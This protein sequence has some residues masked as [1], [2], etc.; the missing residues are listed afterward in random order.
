MQ[1]VIELN[2]TEIM[3]VDGGAITLTAIAAAVVA[4]A[5]VATAANE[6]IEVGEKIHDA[7]CDH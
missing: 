2:E 6:I 1:N 3:A 5:A 7:V 4:V